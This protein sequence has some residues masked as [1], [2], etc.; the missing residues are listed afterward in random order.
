MLCSFSSIPSRI[1]TKPKAIYIYI[2]IYFFFKPPHTKK[3]REKTQKNKNNKKQLPKLN[4]ADGLSSGSWV[5]V[6]WGGGGG[7]SPRSSLFSARNC[8]T[9]DPKGFRVLGLGTLNPKP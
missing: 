4:P 8:P 1:L 2:Y 3:T 9:H 5:V 6:Q 7:A